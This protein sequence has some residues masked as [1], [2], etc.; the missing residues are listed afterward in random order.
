MFFHEQYGPD[1]SSNIQSANLRPYHK[2]DLFDS[3]E[4]VDLHHDL[5]IHFVATSSES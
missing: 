2:S 5:S 4:S 1:R 3:D